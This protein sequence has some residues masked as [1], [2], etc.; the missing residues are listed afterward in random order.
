MICSLCK[1]DLKKNGQRGGIQRWKGHTGGCRGENNGRPPVEP[2]P[3]PGKCLD[4]HRQK[5]GVNPRICHYA[6]WANGE[7]VGTI[8]ARSV[9]GARKA[10]GKGKDVV[11]IPRRDWG[12]DGNTGKS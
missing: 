12:N 1:A 2:D 3:T 5:Q 4:R 10:A 11:L 6:V 9:F 7:R 8:E